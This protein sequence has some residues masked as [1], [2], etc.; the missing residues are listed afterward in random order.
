MEQ[1][2][3]EP[4]RHERGAFMTVYKVMGDKD[5]YSYFIQ[6]STDEEH[7]NWQ[8][9]GTV[10]EKAFEDKLENKEFMDECLRLYRIDKEY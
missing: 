3:A 4:T 8:R 6:I 7:P 1:R 10:F 2:Y 5:D 9:A